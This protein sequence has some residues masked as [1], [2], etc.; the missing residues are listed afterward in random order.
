M[1]FPYFINNFNLR[2]GQLMIDNVEVVSQVK[3]VLKLKKDDHVVLGDGNGQKAEAEIV[4]VGKSSIE[5][6]VVRIFG[7]ESEPTNQVTL[8]CA[9]L[10]KEDLASLVQKTTETGVYKIVPV[11]T[12]RTVKIKVNKLDLGKI[13]KDSAEQAR[14]AILPLLGEVVDL[15]TACADSGQNRLNILFDPSGKSVS[16]LPRLKKPSNIG[17]FIG[18]KGGWSDRELALAKDKGMQIVSLGNTVLQGETAAIIGTYLGSY[19]N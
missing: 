9:L 16:A 1:N 6:F 11:L 19:M 10:K 7:E 13:I 5:V 8:Y 12:D 2:L 14:R 3:N 17:V 18:P 15:E 4:S